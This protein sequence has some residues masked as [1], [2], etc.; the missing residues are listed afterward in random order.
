MDEA[1]LTIQTWEQQPEAQVIMFL[2]F[3]FKMEMAFVMSFD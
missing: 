2:S 1:V 3:P